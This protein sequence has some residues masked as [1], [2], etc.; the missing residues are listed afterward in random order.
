MDQPV[1]PEY[2]RRSL[3]EVLPAAVAALGGPKAP[4][5]DELVLPPSRAIALLLVDGLGHELLRAH[6]ADA[7]FLSALP[8][9]GPL[10]VGFPSSTVVSLASL[11][12]GLPPGA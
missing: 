4:A 1:L 9:A 7:P 2:G 10:T 12:T 3:A 5:S 8:D 11:G 6:A